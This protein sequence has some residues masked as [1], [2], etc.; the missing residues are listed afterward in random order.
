VQLE[1]RVD[2]FSFVHVE[3][4]ELKIAGLA[5]VRH[6]SRQGMGWVAGLQIGSR[7]GGRD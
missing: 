7:S 1:H 3:C 4:H 6:C 5:I 2:P